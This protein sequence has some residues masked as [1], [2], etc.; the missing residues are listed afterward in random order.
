MG[1]ILPQTIKMKWHPNTRQHYI[2]LG[3]NFTHYN[4]YF[5]VNVNHLTKGCTSNVKVQCDY[6]KNI[7]EMSYKQFLKIKSKVYC[8]QY[9]LKHKR[10]ERDENGNL[11]Y[12]EVPYRNRE[13]L[14]NEYVVKDRSANDIAKECGINARTLRDWIAR[15][16]IEKMS[17][18]TKHIT[19]EILY[20]LYIVQHKNTCEIGKMYGVCDGTILNLMKKFG[21]P[22]F[23]NSEA[24]K[25]Y[26]YEKGGLE[27]AR[28]L[29]S[30][31]KN[32]ILCSCRQRGIRVEDFKGFST[33]EQHMSRN[34][35]YYKEWKNKV[36]KRDNYTCQ[37]CGKRGGKLNVHHLYNFSEHKELRYNIDNGIVFCEE[38]HLINYP[39]SFHSVYGEHNNTPDQV[40]EFINNYK[41]SIS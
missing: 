35:T 9:C 18:K 4:D 3:Y 23:S 22:S 21:I 13:W 6:C 8:C 16:N 5:D 12:V 20:N 28:K 7:V 19:K 34:N 38:C 40:Y 39:E 37:R 29:Q 36:L 17:I 31:M 27:K 14:Y 32:R 15:L 25:I 41:E 10:E 30:T 11:F 26:L 33:T 2:D 24:Y 1:L